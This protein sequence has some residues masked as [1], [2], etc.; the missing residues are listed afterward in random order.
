[1]NEP[2]KRHIALDVTSVRV[3]LRNTAKAG[4]SRGV[5]AQRAQHRVTRIETTVPARDNYKIRAYSR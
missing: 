2:F 1:M 4:S 5:P 3:M